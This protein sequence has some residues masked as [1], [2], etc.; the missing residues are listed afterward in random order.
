MNL[1]TTRPDLNESSAYYRGYIA[2]V[3]DGDVVQMLQT[4]HQQIHNLLAQ[5]SD[6]QAE[7]SPA[8]GE[9]SIKQVLHHMIDAER[10]FAFRA[11]WFARGETSELPGMEPNPWVDI[12]NANAR[13]VADLLAEF[14]LVRKTTLHLVSNFSDADLARSG[15]ASGAS[16]TVRALVWIIAGHELHHNQSLR[17]V[18]I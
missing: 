5:V 3:P 10:L 7:K 1:Q 13:T 12:A 14:D 6:A 17:E 15:I 18:Y 8:D 16:V 11:L 2:L 4:Q 9:W